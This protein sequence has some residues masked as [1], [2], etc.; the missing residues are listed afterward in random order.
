[1]R[2]MPDRLKTTRA[3]N[4]HRKGTK[5]RVLLGFQGLIWWLS[6]LYLLV[7]RIFT[8]W[9]LG[10]RISAKALPRWGLQGSEVRIPLPDQ[11]LAFLT[12]DAY[13]Q[14]SQPL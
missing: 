10:A 3:Q 9:E 4:G 1:M 7:I 12:S 11:S 2:S 14:A 13:L 5:I 8:L 6:P